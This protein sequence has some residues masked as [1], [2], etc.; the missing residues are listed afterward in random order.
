MTKELLLCTQDENKWRWIHSSTID[1]NYSSLWMKFH[2]YGS[3][4]L[5]CYC[6]KLNDEYANFL[7][8]IM[9]VWDGC[10]YILSQ[11]AL[12]AVAFGFVYYYSNNC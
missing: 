3:S 1:F 7:G 10:L 9:G 2:F 8:R 12:M 4:N 6:S 11:S 5:H